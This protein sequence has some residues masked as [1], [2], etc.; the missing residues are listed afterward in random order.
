M[1][2]DQTDEQTHRKIQRTAQVEAFV[3]TSL[4]AFPTEGGSSAAWDGIAG[5]KTHQQ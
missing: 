2:I 3:L 4:Q 1:V 5:M